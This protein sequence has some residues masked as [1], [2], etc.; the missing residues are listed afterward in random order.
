M[1]DISI[2][3]ANKAGKYNILTM[4]VRSLI[5][6]TRNCSTTSLHLPPSGVLVCETS[7]EGRIGI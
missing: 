2:C 5:N 4:C 1:P 6:G 3:K 7:Y